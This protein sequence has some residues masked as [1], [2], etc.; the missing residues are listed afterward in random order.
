MR[1]VEGVKQSTVYMGLASTSLPFVTAGMMI[2][3]AINSHNK[4]W[5]EL[6]IIQLFAAAI[7]I[8]GGVISFLNY[9]RRIA[10]QSKC[11]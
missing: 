3:L 6:V 1:A 11:I 9:A 7:S 10:S 2:A 4:S 5:R 8:A